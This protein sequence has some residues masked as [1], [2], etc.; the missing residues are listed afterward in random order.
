MILVLKIRLYVVIKI[1]DY[2]VKIITL[3]CDTCNN[4]F[5]NIVGIDNFYNLRLF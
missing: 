3:L 1:V 4:C 5:V 2:I